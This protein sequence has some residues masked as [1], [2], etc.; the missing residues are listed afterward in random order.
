MS[1]DRTVRY[2]IYMGIM[3]P[4]FMHDLKSQHLLYFVV[5]AVRSD[6]RVRE[7]R[8]IAHRLQEQECKNT[9]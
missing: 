2:I 8:A 7:D 1:A 6:F 9:N 5:C 4:F 3:L